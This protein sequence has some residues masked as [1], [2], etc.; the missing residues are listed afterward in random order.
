MSII[1][2]LTD[3]G[4]DD[5]YVGTMKGVILSINPSAKIIDI[6]HHLDPQDIV[7]AAYLIQSCYA[8]FPKGTVHIVVV[9]PGVGTSRSI[10]ILKTEGYVFLAPDNGV[11]TRV[12]KSDNIDSIVCVNNS[13][14]FLEPVSHTFH[15]RDIF[16]PVGA[17]LSKGVEITKFGATVNKKDIIHLDLPEPCLTDKGELVGS[18]VS[19]DRFGNL[20]TNIDQHRLEKF[21]NGGAEIELVVKIGKGQIRGLSQ[22]YQSTGLKE[23]LAIIGSR[24]YLEIAVNH[25]SA[26]NHFNVQK[27]DSVSVILKNG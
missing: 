27:G 26:R 22:S 20:V 17:H 6:T 13:N 4:T 19:I 15:G 1:S 21:L 3:F 10:I 8:Y 2:L 9:D 11:L 25:E 7:Q 14:F 12:M 16:A 5:E 18:I 23:P 24:G